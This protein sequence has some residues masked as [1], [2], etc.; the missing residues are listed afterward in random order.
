VRI[1][2]ARV[3]DLTRG[4][5]ERPL[6]IAGGRIAEAGEG[7]AYQAT[8]C[9]I[10]PGL[11]DLHFHGCMGAD[12]SDG[13]EQ[14]LR[15]IAAYQLSRGVTQI[16]P[17]GMTLPE[18]ELIEMC[19]AAA[20]YRREDPP[21]AKLCGIHLEGP[22]LSAAKKGAQQ[23]DWLHLP[24]WALVERLQAESKGLCKLVS[25][26]PELPG[27]LEFIAK[28][29]DHIRVSLAHT[30]ADYDTA[31]AAFKAGA[32]H[33]THLFNAMPPFAHRAPGV[34]GA[35]AD[36]PNCMVE[37]IADGVHLHPA[38]VRAAFKIFGPE[39][40]ILVSDSMRAT[41]MP[42]GDY[43]LG[44]QTVRVRGNKPL[45]PDGTLAGSATD[46][47]GCMLC[48][49]S[50]GIPLETAVRCASYN[51][52]RALGLDDKAGSLQNGK[53]ADLVVLDQNLQI[54]AVVQAGRFV[55][56]ELPL[57]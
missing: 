24:D 5:V 33:V 23:G 39:R 7:P 46:L 56:G 27:A 45:L 31:L 36:A 44:G 13:S 50:M 51:P 42:D 25:L 37:L 18:A 22:F 57:A 35:A 40:V 8:G 21:G 2:G 16:C 3:F 9:T 41:G 34:V 26:A 55:W 14:G 54:K 48:A 10:I 20:A 17:A 11:I 4:F 43:T 1:S 47:T 6:H 19:R 12:F 53:Q 30:E 49:V 29:K 38:M 52:A 15:A 32:S 28:A